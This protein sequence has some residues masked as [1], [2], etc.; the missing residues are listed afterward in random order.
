MRIHR[1]VGAL[2][3][4]AIALLIAA[5]A[6]SSTGASMAP[7]ADDALYGAAGEDGASAPDARSDPNAPD[8]EPGSGVGQLGAVDD[9]RIVRTGQIDLEVSDIEAALR[10]ARDAIRAMGGYIGA[11]QT[12]DQGDQPVA[13]ITYR[14][15]ADR[16][17][18]ALDLLRDLNGLT[19]KVV[20]EQTQSA[21][22]TGQVIDLEARIRNLR[23]SEAALQEIATQAVRIPDVLEVQAQLTNIRGEIEALTAQ[24][25]DLEDRADF[26]TLTATFTVPIVAVEVAAEGWDPIAV[27]D[28]ATASLVSL[29]QGLTSVG[30]WFVIVWL[31]ILATIGAIVL[32]TAW[33]L[34][35]AGVLGRRPTEGPTPAG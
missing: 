24:L 20:A 10:S 31:P 3:P 22:V 32:A 14:I 25:A 6:G 34:R 19:T 26:A 9:A 2:A 13:S 4:I 23:A 29:L 21:E 12:Y 35:R 15:P 7:V 5:C 11:S 28:E 17:E 8:A 1:L 16:W 18:D 27:V 30:I 33:V